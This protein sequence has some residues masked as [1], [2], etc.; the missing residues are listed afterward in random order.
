MAV[1]GILFFVWICLTF[2]IYYLAC[3]KAAEEEKKE[4]Y[5]TQERCAW[6]A[7]HQQS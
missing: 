2:F 5:K 1:H 6:T 7:K 4:T 3:P